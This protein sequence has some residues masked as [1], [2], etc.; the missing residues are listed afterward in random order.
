MDV[1]LAKL[2]VLNEDCLAEIL[3]FL[4]NPAGY[5]ARELDYIQVI[6]LRNRMQLLRIGIEIRAWY[7][8]NLNVVWLRPV[9][10]DN[11]F[12][13]HGA[14]RNVADE[15]WFTNHASS[16]GWISVEDANIITVYLLGN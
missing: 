7:T 13:Y 4:Y 11:T 15:V 12:Q 8:R 2:T 1:I 16:N 10:I 9:K 3:K 5:T 14:Y 6:R